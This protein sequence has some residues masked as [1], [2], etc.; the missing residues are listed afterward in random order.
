MGSEMCIRDRYGTATP[1]RVTRPARVTR[2]GVAVPYYL[3]ED[4]KV[5][6]QLRLKNGKFTEVERRTG[7]RGPNRVTWD[8]RR[9][10]RRVPAGEYALRLVA[11][12]GGG[13]VGRAPVRGGR[14]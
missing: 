13:A 7:V 3:A 12:T 9:N 4:A 14:P 6:L 11:T 1:V 10:G 2:T 8:L 5:V